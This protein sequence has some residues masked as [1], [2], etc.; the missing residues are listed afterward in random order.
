MTAAPA[1]H[2]L[3]EAE[4][5]F[6]AG[7]LDAS[8][9]VLARVQRYD[10]AYP[11]ALYLRAMML[12]TTGSR[13]Q[14]CALLEEACR[15]CPESRDMQA[16]RARI[17]TDLGRAAEALDILSTLAE[18]G[19]MSAAM[20]LD[21]G[22]LARRL[23]KFKL[24]MESFDAALTLDP[25]F[26]HAWS[27]KANLLHEHGYYAEALRCHDAAVAR[28][29]NN[30]EVICNRTATLNRLGRVEEAFAESN[31]ALKIAPDDPGAW[32]TCG[33]TLVQMDDTEQAMRC[34]EQALRIDPA[35]RPAFSN[36][37]STLATLGKHQEALELFEA[38]MNL[39]QAYPSEL[40]ALRAKEGMLKLMLGDWRGWEGY[41]HRL[42]HDTLPAMH[43]LLA[44]RWTGRQA[45]AGKTILLWSE[46]GYGDT[47]QF[48]RYAACVAERGAAVLLEVPASLL[49]LCRQLPVASVHVRGTPL[50]A[51]DF[52]ISM[53]SMPLALGLHTAIP[54][55]HAYLRAPDEKVR[56]WAAR[57]PPRGKRP[58]VGIVCSGSPHNNGNATRSMPLEAFAPLTAQVDLIVLQPELTLEDGS[59]LQNMPGVLKAEVDINDFADVAGLI[60]NTDLVLSVDTA[61]AHLTGALG[62]PLWLLL[63]WQAEWRWM[64]SRHDTPWYESARLY[65][66]CSRGNWNSVIA[67][68]AQAMTD[69]FL[70]TL[71]Q[72]R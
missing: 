57:L 35:H 18:A 21:R 49:N 22:T 41:E 60:A 12:A 32:T 61:I 70:L 40:A 55:P 30:V 72:W 38:A 64:I 63:P 11:Y 13:E 67:A 56:E 62:H 51:H 14:G 16:M 52:Q 28:E 69:E 24:A 46:Q 20:A 47:I 10:P 7:E 42:M 23:G 8:K 17:Y 58:L 45:L 1:M 71:R 6:A 53:M 25:D 37:A 39:A 9:D 15:L 43:D 29:P 44:P 36:R 50:P 2:A 66:Q 33:C 68:V 31:R 4:R 34:F 65:R 26:T 19:N 59:A 5:L 3:Q 54:H 27:G 48:C